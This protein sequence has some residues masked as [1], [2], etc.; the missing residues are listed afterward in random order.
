VTSPTEHPLYWFALHVKHRHEKHVA[1]SLEGKGYESFL[2][3][4]TMVHQRSKRFELPL[5]PGYVFCRLPPKRVLPAIATPGVFSIVSNGAEPAPISDG[6]LEGVRRMVE[7]GSQLR[8][9][10]YLAPGQDVCVTSGPLRGLRGV[11]VNDSNQTWVV[12][13]VHLL[14]RSV[15]LKVERSQLS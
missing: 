6:E 15:A 3:T 12:V 5:F 2:P 7:S 4:Y 8:P 10:S 14:Q 11:V 13:S 1:A 9:W